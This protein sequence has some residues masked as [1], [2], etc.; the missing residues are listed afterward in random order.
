MSGKIISNEQIAI[1]QFFVSMPE[2]FLLEF[3]INLN[4]KIKDRIRS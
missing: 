2:H 1:N 3:I 4:A